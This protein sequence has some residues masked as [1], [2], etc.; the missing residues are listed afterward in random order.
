MCGVGEQNAEN[1]VTDPTRAQESLP[2][3]KIIVPWVYLQKTNSL[4][5][6]PLIFKSAKVKAEC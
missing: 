2:T 1:A 5:F 4:H 6:N 3:T